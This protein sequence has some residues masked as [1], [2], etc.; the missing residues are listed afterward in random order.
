MDENDFFCIFN[1]SRICLSTVNIFEQG[2][3]KGRPSGLYAGMEQKKKEESGSV[4][5]KERETKETYI[6]KLGEL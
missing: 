2:N 6:N 3:K 5:G 1:G 4:K